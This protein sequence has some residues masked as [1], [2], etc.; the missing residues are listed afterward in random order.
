MGFDTTVVRYNGC[1]NVY[2]IVSGHRNSFASGD[3][4]TKYGLTKRIY[5]VWLSHTLFSK[6]GRAKPSVDS[7]LSGYRERGSESRSHKLYL[8]D[9]GTDSV[10]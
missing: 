10:C 8:D 4:L 3:G 5:L 7:Q 1:L 2:T 6:L 9:P